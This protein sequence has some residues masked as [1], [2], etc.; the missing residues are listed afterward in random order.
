MRPRT[1]RPERLRI[2]AIAAV[3]AGTLL[4]GT[5][6]ASAAP[7]EPHCDHIDDSARPTVRPGDVSPAVRQVQCLVNQYSGY[8]RWLEEDGT[9]GPR[10]QDGVR[11]VQNCNGTTGGPD[12]IVGPST[13]SRLYTPK[14][15]CA[16]PS[17]TAEHAEQ[18]RQSAHD[19]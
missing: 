9:Y 19:A 6:V 15:E 16:F 11:W 12:G 2:A 3:V 13:W 10:T 18:T 1:H 7:S 14:P 8:P 5:P 4:T 17:A